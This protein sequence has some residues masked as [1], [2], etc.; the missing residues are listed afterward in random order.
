[1]R[2]AVLGATGTVGRALLPLL[3]DEHDLVAVSR[4]VPSDGEGI[5]WE[6][7]DVTDGLSLRRAWREST[8]RSRTS[9]PTSPPRPVATRCSAGRSTRAGPTS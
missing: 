1:M 6:A 5:H 4:R 2:I 7:A 3:A 9:P 8:S